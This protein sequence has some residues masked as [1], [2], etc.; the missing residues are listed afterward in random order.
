MATLLGNLEIIKGQS[1][2]IADYGATHQVQAAQVLGQQIANLDL[3]ITAVKNDTIN[4]I[5]VPPPPPPN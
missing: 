5:L 4:P 2:W 3:M 1:D